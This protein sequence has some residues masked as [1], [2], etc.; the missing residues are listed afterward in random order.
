MNKTLCVLY[1]STMATFI[2][3]HI[4][5]Q[6][7][8][9]GT[10]TAKRIIITPLFSLQLFHP[11]LLVLFTPFSLSLTHPFSFFSTFYQDRRARRERGRVHDQGHE[12]HKEGPGVPEQGQEEEDYDNVVHDH[13][14]KPRVLHWTQIPGLPINKYN[15]YYTICLEILWIYAS[16][17]H[18]F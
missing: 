5:E 17:G 2:C 6:N 7:P 11:F 1:I 12:R 15:D 18:L 9:F 10:E 13:R 4:V 16:E 14:R 8:F 3:Y